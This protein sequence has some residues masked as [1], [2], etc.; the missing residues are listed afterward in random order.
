MKL[1]KKFEALPLLRRSPLLS[2]CARKNMDMDALQK[3]IAAAMQSALK[4]V[5]VRLD[6]LEDSASASP[7]IAQKP[8]NVAQKV[9]Q[10]QEQKQKR[11]PTP[12]ATDELRKLVRDTIMELID[13]ALLAPEHAT[14]LF[15]AKMYLGKTIGQYTLNKTF[16][17]VIVNYVLDEHNT[18]ATTE[19][20]KILHDLV[21]KRRQYHQK[22]WKV[23][24]ECKNLKYGGQVGVMSAKLVALYN[25]SLSKATGKTQ[26]AKKTKKG[27][28]REPQ[29]RKLPKKSK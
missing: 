6:K 24:K 25:Q 12:K 1:R 21:L 20:V 26:K 5:L 16:F 23:K 17:L 19:N 3:S 18:D 13:A 9:A 7:L 15:P 10:K 27:T 8:E 28:T 11:L 4:P 29:R 2:P 22:S 14:E